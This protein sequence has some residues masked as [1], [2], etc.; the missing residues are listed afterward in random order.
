[1]Y[2]KLLPILKAYKSS[3][4]A[5][6]LQSY[7]VERN[8]GEI[9][10]SQNVP[11]DL[12]EFEKLHNIS[13]LTCTCIKLSSFRIGNHTKILSLSIPIEENRIIGK[14][15]FLHEFTYVFTEELFNSL[16]DFNGVSMI[17]KMITRMK[18]L[19][20]LKLLG[21]APY[22]DAKTILKIADSVIKLKTY[23]TLIVDELNPSIHKSNLR[24]YTIKTG[25][26]NKLLFLNW[27]LVSTKINII[28]EGVYNFINFTENSIILIE[29]NCIKHLQIVPGHVTFNLAQN[30]REIEHLRISSIRMFEQTAALF[31][32]LYYVK[33][34]TFAKECWDCGADTNDNEIYVQLAERVSQMTTLARIRGFLG[35][36][37]LLHLSRIHLA[38]THRLSVH[39]SSPQSELIPELADYITSS[40]RMP[41]PHRFVFDEITCP[42]SNERGALI[43]DLIKNY[44]THS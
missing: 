4:V 3:L 6:K 16:P 39:M 36:Q 31:D 12:H 19:R 2:P 5:L 33:F 38:R 7:M 37:F 44:I 25:Q 11:F 26:H 30:K 34:I 14:L 24:E 13:L 40:L 21:S 42:T 9:A 27:Q 32:P 41:Q 10:N 20:V 35:Q 29:E 22:F 8:E 17:V 28:V 43:I 1:M 18:S 23:T 15:N